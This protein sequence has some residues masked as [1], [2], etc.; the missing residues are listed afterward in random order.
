MIPLEDNNDEK[1]KNWREDYIGVIPWTLQEKDDDNEVKTKMNEL[2]IIFGR[3][4]PQRSQVYKDED[5]HC[6]TP[7]GWKW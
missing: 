1:M 5:G 4:R 3:W 2:L 6:T 7:G